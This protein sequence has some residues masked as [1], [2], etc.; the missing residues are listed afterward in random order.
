MGMYIPLDVDRRPDI[1]LSHSSDDGEFALRL[2]TDLNVCEVDVW[3]DKWEIE[4]GDSLYDKISE[5]IQ[6]SKFV[7][8]LFSESFIKKKWS[9]NEVKAAFSRE[10][11][12]N[13]KVIIPLIYEKIEVPPLITD[14]LYISF[15]KNYYEGLFR[16]VGLIHG[17]KLIH[18]SAALRQKYPTNLQ[19]VLSLLEYT[20]VDPY[21]ILPK[22][23][24]DEL[25]SS[26][27]GTLEGNRVRFK[28]FHLRLDVELSP[29]TQEYVNKV[30]IIHDDNPKYRY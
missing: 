20:G 3:I 9:S 4:P 2:A 28:P 16:L 26:G 21:M 25:V 7:A 22:D 13:R 8:L 12:K 11:N 14:K 19:D 23:V 30:L 27:F 18:I 5:G 10:I 6:N 24:F 29:R 1:F 15:E 17:I